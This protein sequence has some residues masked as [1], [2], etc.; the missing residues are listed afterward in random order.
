MTWHPHTAD[1]CDL[2][3]LYNNPSSATDGGKSSGTAGAAG[4]GCPDQA[5]KAATTS[6]AEITNSKI[7]LAGFGATPD[8]SLAYPFGSYNAAVE[9]QVKTG[10]F[11]AARTID[12]GFNTQATNPYALVVQDLDETTPVS[13]VEAWINTAV[14]NKVWLI[15]VFHQIDSL[16][17]ANDI[18]D[19]TPQTLQSIVTYL[20]QNHDCVLTVGQVMSGKT[21]CP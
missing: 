8:N 10:G 6:Q 13:T 20:G 4:I 12:E 9:Q 5:L 17:N 21:S 15:L 3:A 18:Y 11:L 14:A 1:H 16:A 7:E 2:V 19:V